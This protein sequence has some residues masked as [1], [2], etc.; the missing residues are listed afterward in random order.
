MK[1]KITNIQISS[2]NYFLVRAY[3]IGI[4]FN[5][6]IY[7][8]RQDSW[9]IPLLSIIP[10]ILLIFF[11]DYIMNYEPSLNLSE[12]ILKLFK[13]KIGSI[14]IVLYTLFSFMMCVVNYLNLN[15][16]IQSQ[17]L[18][19]TPIL[20]ISIVFG[21]ATLY[22]LFKDILV[23]C[24]TSN[25]L[26]Y[27]NIILFLV[28]FL[29]LIPTSNLSNLMPIFQSNIT[30]YMSGINCFYAF[31]IGPIF[32]LT[33]IPKNNIK[34]KKLKNSLI[35]SYIIAIITLFITIF[36]TLATFGYELTY[37]FEYAE[38][39]VLKHVS[40]LGLS[41]RIESILVMQFLFDVLIFNI[42]ILYFIGNS[43]KNVTKLKNINLIYFILNILL[44][45]ATLYI[46]NYNI[47]L[48]KFVTNIIPTVASI[49]ITSLIFL[50][51][52]KIKLSKH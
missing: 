52:I 40:L 17:F 20:V 21:V 10:G 3:I 2:L 12:K 44:I 27:I 41:S 36:V 39:H 4:T 16:F 9:I 31:N 38:F 28:S 25:I 50:L 46:S 13:N 18:N 35:L 24:R 37:L 23:I 26:F 49:F 34:S 42:F 19:K 33:I 22:I 32:L 14:I 29:G 8:T 15:N 7:S 5:A 45:F 43:I 48:D 6:L 51:C 47:F 1:N 30:D 11:I